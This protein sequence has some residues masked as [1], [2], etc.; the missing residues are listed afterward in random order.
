AAV[1]WPLAP[2]GLLGGGVFIAVGV[3]GD[4]GDPMLVGGRVRVLAA[5]VYTELTGWA[6]V[7]TSAALG[8]FLL[9]PAVLF[10]AAL[11]R[12]QAATSGRFQ[13]VGGRSSGLARTS[14]ASG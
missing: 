14:G 3:L 8:L 10:F 2:R 7:G 1:T 5:E 12:V 6:S 11:L 13:S 4:F 9:V